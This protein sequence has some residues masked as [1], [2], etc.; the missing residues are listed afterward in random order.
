MDAPVSRP[1]SRGHQLILVRR[2]YL[3][4]M[5][6]TMENNIVRGV[7]L[8]LYWDKWKR[9]WKLLFNKC[10]RVAVLATTKRPHIGDVT[11][12]RPSI[13]GCTEP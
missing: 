5:E 1:G 13:C 7:M 4:M 2:G 6:N 11:P 8:R 3:G 12:E 9:K 10:M